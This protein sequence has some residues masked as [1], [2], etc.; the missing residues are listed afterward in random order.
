[1]RIQA[2]NLG[3]DLE[4]AYE[5]AARDLADQVERFSFPPRIRPRLLAL[6]A[7]SHHTSNTMALWAQVRDRLSSQW[8]VEEIGLRNG[9]LSDCSGC[10]YTMC[11]HFGERGGCFYGGVMSEEVYPA[12]R[13]ADALILMCPNYNDALSANLTAFINRLTALFR[14]TRFYDKA[15]FALV[16]SGYSGSDTVARQLIS[17]LNMNKSF[18]LPPRFALLETANSPGEALSAPGIQDRLDRFAAG[19]EGLFAENKN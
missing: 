8:Q 11:L 7:S 9:T 13:K 15:V 2:K 14:Q 10:P 6:H 1:F 19:M 4:G 16:V 3:S 12:V 17:A 18:Y 5:A